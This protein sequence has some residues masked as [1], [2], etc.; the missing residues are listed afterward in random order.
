LKLTLFLLLLPVKCNFVQVYS[1]TLSRFGAE[2]RSRI[3]ATL[4]VKGVKKVVCQSYVIGGFS[5]ISFFSHFRLVARLGLTLSL[6]KSQL[7]DS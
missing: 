7:C 4:A 6:P 2:P 1:T 3:I 5:S